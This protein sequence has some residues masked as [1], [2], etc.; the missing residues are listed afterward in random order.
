MA[1]QWSQGEK[2]SNIL[3]IR[4]AKIAVSIQR[5]AIYSSRMRRKST[6]EA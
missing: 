3:W 6:E 1:G 5:K 4:G 2:M